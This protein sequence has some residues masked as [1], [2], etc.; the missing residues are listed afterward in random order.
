MGA[1]A[2][3]AA[4]KLLI[5]ANT[6]GTNDIHYWIQFAQG[7][8]DF[9]PVGM[10]GHEFRVLYN[11]PP[12]IGW[13]LLAIGWLGE[14]LMSFPFWMR[15]PS[16]LAD[17]GTAVLVFEL[18]RRRRPPPE[19][20]IAGLAISASPLLFIVSGFHGNT[21]PVF[22]ALSLLALYLVLNRRS[23]LLAGLAIGLAVSVKLVPVIFVPLLVV[24]VLRRGQ[25]DVV[26]FLAGGTAVFALL[27]LPVLVF[28]G[29][30][31]L[32]QV[33]G[34]PGI[35]LRQWGLPQLLAWLHAP[36][37]VQDVVVDPGR[38][39]VLAAAA[40]LPAALVWRRPSAAAPALALAASLFLFLSPA[41]GMQY[42]VWPL[43]A[44]YLTKNGPAHLYNV[45]SSVFALVVYSL[46][47]R[48][49][50][51]WG[52]GEAL[53]IPLAS[54]LHF[55]LMLVCWASLGLL[56]Y[57]SYRAC[58]VRVAG[59][60]AAVADRPRDVRAW[61]SRRSKVPPH[62]AVGAGEH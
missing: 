48:G 46:W 4:L 1:A 58:R 42:L 8:R 51:P 49:A 57:A 59:E 19:A 32:A 5:A 44:A 6:F 36:Q 34:Y 2:V 21:D 38:L 54:P 52:W 55:T 35:A 47:S 22:V 43:A 20:A 26:R 27:W 61:W 30:E 37:G 24:L 3:A 29:S 28:R 15:V 18:V 12:M 53:A 17:V 13:L 7:A 62:G 50:W 14:H 33:V 40:A 31:F 23:P 41:F 11:H 10:Y 56:A 9:G 60:S 25:R 16:I 45:G 39:L